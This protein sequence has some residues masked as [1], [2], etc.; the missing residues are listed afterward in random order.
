[1][2]CLIWERPGLVG[3]LPDTVWTCCGGL[4][5]NALRL[6]LMVRWFQSA[7]LNMDI[8]A[9]I[10]CIIGKYFFLNLIYQTWTPLIHL[11][12]RRRR[13]D[14]MYVTQHSDQTHFDQN[15]AYCI[16]ID[17]L[18]NI[19]ELSREDFLRETTNDSYQ[20]SFQMHCRRTW[21]P[22]PA[23]SVKNEPFKSQESTSIK[24]V[25]AKCC[26]EL[27]CMFLFIFIVFFLILIMEIKFPCCLFFILKL[28][29]QA[30]FV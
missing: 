21:F 15:Q 18:K 22:S 2:I 12:P 5:I 20:I 3:R 7:I 13:F 23:R 24:D 17:L 6:T 29:I 14:K 4:L 9:L 26:I 10:Y 28:C 27:Y 1:M 11:E 25:C 19:K 8:L 16:S 30:P